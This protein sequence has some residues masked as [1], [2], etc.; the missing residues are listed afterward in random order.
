[1]DLYN[2]CLSSL[3]VSTIKRQIQHKY[4]TKQVI[5]TSGYVVATD[6]LTHEG[7]LT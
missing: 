1:M 4:N 7:K 5:Y 6:F 2:L 3:H